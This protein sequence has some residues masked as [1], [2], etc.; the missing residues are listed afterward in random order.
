MSIETGFLFFLALL[1]FAVTP[2]PGIFA[3]LANSLRFGALAS[4]PLALGMAISDIVYLV[5]ACLG[6][7][8]LAETGHFAFTLIRYIGAAY[9]IYLAWQMWRAPVESVVADANQD[10]LKEKRPIKFWRGFL[11]GLLIS[12]SNPKVILFYLAFLPTFL[13]LSQLTQTDIMVASGL[14]F[15]GLMIGL[16]AVAAL[17][18]SARK[19]LRSARSVRLMNRISASIMGT[20]GVYLA[21]RQA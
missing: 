14:A 7:A 1:V 21:S 18:G 5:A 15:A 19:K 3:I 8:A 20:A 11:Q 6:L 4:L 10:V 9:L 13:D 17:A 12:M 16:M 2:G